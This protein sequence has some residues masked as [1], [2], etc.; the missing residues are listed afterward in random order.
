MEKI[1]FLFPE[2]ACLL[3]NR[4]DCYIFDTFSISFNL[5]LFHNYD[6]VT[7][8]FPHHTVPYQQP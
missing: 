3:F 8:L 7:G 6:G 2:K 1:D 4:D 5:S